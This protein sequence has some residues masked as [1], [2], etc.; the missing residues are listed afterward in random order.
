[1]ISVAGRSIGNGKATLSL[2][3]IEPAELT[4]G[5]G[6]RTILSGSTDCLWPSALHTALLVAWSC[7][8]REASRSSC[9]GVSF[10][11]KFRRGQHTMCS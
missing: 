7:L 6:G 9:D 8:S 3:K 1:M 4:D 5:G 10:A 2:E 11:P